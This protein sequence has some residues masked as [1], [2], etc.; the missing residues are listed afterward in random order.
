MLCIG[1]PLF[2]VHVSL[3]VYSLYICC[4]E[5]VYVGRS[6]LID[7]DINRG[8]FAGRCFKEGDVVERCP[9]IPIT[10]R[11]FKGLEDTTLGDYPFSFNGSGTCIVLGYG[12]L[13]NHSYSPNI[14][15]YDDSLE[16]VFYALRDIEK[17]EELLYNYNGMDEDERDVGKMYGFEK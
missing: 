14:Y 4:M 1:I 3:Y 8:V 6:S 17:G 7:G 15:W 16:K 2:F 10:E 13:Y 11:E 9:V 5:N 12:S